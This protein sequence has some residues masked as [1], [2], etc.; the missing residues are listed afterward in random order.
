MTSG[1]SVFGFFG[2]VLGTTLSMVF[3]LIIW[4]IVDGKTPGVIVFLWLFIFVEMYFFLKYPRF[5]AIWLVCII[6]QVLIIAYELQVGVLGI[7]VATQTGQKYYPVYELG[8]YRL[9][10][11]AGGSLV[12]FI[13][14]F[15]PYPLTDRSWLRKDLGA[16]I[17]LLANFYSAVHSTINARMHGTEGNMDS[18][19]SPGRQLDKVRHQ[20]FGKLML[21]LPSLKTHA[22]F[23]KWEMNLGGKFP[24]ETYDEI[25][26]RV[27]NIMSY[28]SLISYSSQIWS[29]TNTANDQINNQSAWAHDL[30]AVLDTVGPTSHGITSVL[31]L[32]SAAV[33]S[34]SAL[35]AH[36]QLPQPYQ[37]SHRLEQLD[38]GILDTRH[39][40]EPGYAAYAVMQVASSMITDDL[41]KLVSNV[42]DLVGEVDF[43]FRIIDSDST[44]NSSESDGNGKGKKD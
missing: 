36:V 29:C 10:T 32:L 2:R 25:I 6:T 9:A 41:E 27:Q 30:T 18:K 39:V 21:L 3:S 22:D 17:Y 24:R 4:Y 33:R 1:Q 15:F 42:K 7:A 37:L 26:L 23:Q 38:K 40:E 12:A 28:L 14:T 31:S 5:L 20:I 19:H 44:V 8:P 43:S 11:T 35:P 13:W 34:G 16:T